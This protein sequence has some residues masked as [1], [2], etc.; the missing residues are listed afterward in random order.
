MASRTVILALVLVVLTAGCSGDGGTA[1]TTT[2]GGTDD[3]MTT[4]SGNAGSDDADDGSIEPI[5]AAELAAAQASLRE[6]GSFTATWSFSGTDESGVSSSIRYAYA[7]DVTDNRAHVVFSAGG[8]GQPAAMDWEQYSAEGVTYSFFGS[9]A[10]AYYQS[11]E[12]ELD[13]IDDAISWAGLYAYDDYEGFEFV[14][15]EQFDG[16][17]V[18]RYELSD[19]QEAFWSANAAQTDADSNFEVTDFEYVVLIDGDG[20]SR[21]EA[22]SYAGQTADG[23]SVSGEW[24]YSLT[25]VG[26]TTVPEPE[27]LTDA[28]AQS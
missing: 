10:G 1:P 16:V 12:S 9:E 28:K 6:A 23:R 13:V 24:E 25:G 8:D 17:T 2:A 22:W 26:T 21:F 11:E 5:D 4:T 3:S 15:T 14:G 27:W 18:R 20:L 19:L 7:A